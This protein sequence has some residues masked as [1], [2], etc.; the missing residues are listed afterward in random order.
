[1]NKNEWVIFNDE[2]IQAKDVRI[3]P[4]SS[5]IQ[6]GL[7][8]F[9]GMR[10][11]CEENNKFIVGINQHFARLKTSAQAMH[12]KTY[13]SKGLLLDW[14]NDLVRLRILIIKKQIW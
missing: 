5:S 1:M 6:Y 9:E 3:D 4:L 12:L 11:Y 10:V 14:I 2:L 7:N 13:H 8:V